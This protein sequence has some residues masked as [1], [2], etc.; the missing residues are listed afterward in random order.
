MAGAA[1]SVVIEICSLHVASAGA[2][3]RA[4]WTARASK[5]AAVYLRRWAASPRRQDDCA[6]GA[7]PDMRPDR[8]ADEVDGHRL[9][10]VAR[11]RGKL[12][13]ELLDVRALAVQDRDPLRRAVGEQLEQPRPGTPARP[14][15]VGRL[16]HAV[17]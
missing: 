2:I 11:C 12:T 15:L 13:R 4:P 5:A 9:A 1:R 14:R 7:G 10:R 6:V 8:G 3:G 17:V 16:D